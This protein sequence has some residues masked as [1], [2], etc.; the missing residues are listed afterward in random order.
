MCSTSSE[1]SELEV[2][3]S[4]SYDASVEETSSTDA[5]TVHTEGSS[6]EISESDSQVSSLLCA[7]RPP[8]PSQLARKRKLQCN[9]SAH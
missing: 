3:T 8:R 9:P 7:L 4:S 6:L 5:D 2:G 1:L